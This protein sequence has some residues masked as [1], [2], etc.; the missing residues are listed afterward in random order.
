M[1]FQKEIL[2]IY[3]MSVLLIIIIK[4]S[5]TVVIFKD[6]RRIM[7]VKNSSKKLEL[8]ESYFKKKTLN[9]TNLAFGVLTLITLLIGIVTSIIDVRNY[10]KNLV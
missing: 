4:F 1:I 5:L 3:L 8:I 10:Y 7:N 2:L 6:I 9:D